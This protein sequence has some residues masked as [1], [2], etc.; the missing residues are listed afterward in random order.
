MNRVLLMAVGV[1]LL[2]ST[3]RPLL[4]RGPTSWEMYTQGQRHALTPLVG[5]LSIFSALCGGFLVFGLVQVGYEGGLSGYALGLAYIVGLPFLLWAL[6]KARAIEDLR[7]G[8][9]GIDRIIFRHYGPKTTFCYFLLTSVVFAGVLGGQLLA[10]SFYL[11]SFSGL[12]N[13]VIVLGAGLVPTVAYTV[14]Y[15]FRG[16]IS[17]DIIQGVF[18]LAI[19]FVVPTV[20]YLQVRALPVISFSR[21]SEE[22]VGSYGW[23]YPIFGFI[24]LCPS[25]IVRA[26]IWQRMRIVEKKHQFI[27]LSATAL[28][29]VWFYVSMTSAGLLIRQNPT[30]FGSLQTQN[31]GSLV[32][33]I[34]Q[35]LIDNGPLQFLCLTGILFAILS[36]VDSYLNIVALSTT[37]LLLWNLESDPSRPAE[38]KVSILKTNAQVTTLAVGIVAIVLASAIPDL[39]DLL[40]ASFSLVG[41]LL[42]VV[43]WALYR[44]NGKN[45]DYVGAIPLATSLVSLIILFPVL[46]K[47]AFI[48]AVLLGFL[49]FAVLVFIDRKRKT[50]PQD[51]QVEQIIHSSAGS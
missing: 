26:D 17:N 15:G 7:E 1:A 51:V 37:R 14:R 2:V 47:I 31:P 3:L 29:L 11:S 6:N 20:V 16:V 42:P 46:R 39:V 19:S 49:V 45:S 44:K 36:S 35:V 27:V 13:W 40:S 28:A 23:L 9:F 50:N 30:S 8:W 38:E 48:P 24:F 34:I 4:L 32:P 5:F 18:A 33:Q 21:G 22:I 25:F 43:G 41:I 12:G 10:V